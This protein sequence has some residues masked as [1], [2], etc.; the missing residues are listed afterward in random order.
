M[1]P[2]VRFASLALLVA[3]VLTP[4]G[5]AR[6]ATLNLL[7]DKPAYFPG[8]PVTILLVGDSEGAVGTAM[9]ARL[10]FDP[11]GLVGAQSQTFVPP[12]GGT[13]TWTPGALQSCVQPGVCYMMNMIHLPLAT[14]GGVDPAVEPFTYGVLT[15]TAGAP[16][17]YEIDVH[18]FVF[19]DLPSPPEG[20]FD[21]VNQPDRF[22]FIVPEP[23][24]AA[25][26]AL[27]LGSLAAV[28]RR[29]AR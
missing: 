2:R 1:A 22:L 26:L 13:G 6:A 29:A 18:A 14:Q 7:L 4:W 27:G 28:R 5:G 23:G 12:T 11:T 17:T 19:F 16:G 20:V 21:V 3:A 10:H 9:N 8:D 15:A 25:L 24:T